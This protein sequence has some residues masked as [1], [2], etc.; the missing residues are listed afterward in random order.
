MN[1][2]DNLNINIKHY[3]PKTGNEEGN[4][5]CNG[6]CWYNTKCKISDMQSGFIDSGA[7]MEHSIHD[8]VFI[9]V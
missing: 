7:E 2:S 8:N 9:R 5:V 6:P 4:S 1:C 3:Q